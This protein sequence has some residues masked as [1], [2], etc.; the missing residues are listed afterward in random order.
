MWG[1]LNE[2]LNDGTPDDVTRMNRE[3]EVDQ[4]LAVPI[5]DFK[6]SPYQWW[7][8]HQHQYQVLTKLAKR[9]LSAPPTSVNSERVFSGAGLLYSD[10]RCRLLPAL[11]EKLLLIKYNYLLAGL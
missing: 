8:I 9:Y 4:Y 2:I 10:Q 7:E 6:S 5:I 1:C 11:A 3:S